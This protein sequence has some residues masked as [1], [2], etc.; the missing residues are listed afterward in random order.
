[1]LAAGDIEEYSSKRYK[2]DDVILVVCNPPVY[3]DIHVSDQ[4]NEAQHIV[5]AVMGGSKV[6]EA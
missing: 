6:A 2:C 3:K 5:T 4:T 1:M